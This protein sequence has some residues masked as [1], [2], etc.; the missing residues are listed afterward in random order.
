MKKMTSS[1]TVPDIIR[2]NPVFNS[3]YGRIHY[4][5]RNYLGLNCGGT[6]SGKSWGGLT[7]CYALDRDCTGKPRFDIDNVIFLPSKFLEW[8]R[9]KPFTGSF[10]MWDEAG[11]GLAS[12]EWYSR[13]NQFIVKVLTTFRFQRLGVIFT[14]KQNNYFILIPCSMVLQETV[15]IVGPDLNGWNIME[16]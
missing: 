14:T 6:G 7:E 1:V 13:I 8:V 5:N 12:R 9:S 2:M 11:V 10:I 15:V 4:Y 16:N 3:I